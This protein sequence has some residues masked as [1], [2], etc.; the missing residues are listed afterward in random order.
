MW[1]GVTIFIASAPSWFFSRE[2]GYIAANQA[3]PIK[4][5]KKVCIR[6][7]DT[8]NS[9]QSLTKMYHHTA[10]ETLYGLDGAKINCIPT[11]AGV[12]Y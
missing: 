10:T 6:P 8:N 5:A 9:T 7:Y 1:R 12:S 2:A 11:L 4:Q 3:I